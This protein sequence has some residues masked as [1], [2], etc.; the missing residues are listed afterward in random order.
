MALT[1]DDPVVLADRRK[2]HG[3]KLK[4]LD[5][6]LVRIMSAIADKA[7]LKDLAA[8]FGVH[9]NL[10]AKVKMGAYGVR[11]QSEGATP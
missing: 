5:R 6:D 8:Q 11:V 1:V 9:R 3:P 7:L 4:F 2:A 10:I